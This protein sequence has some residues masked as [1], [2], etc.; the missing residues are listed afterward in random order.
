MRG[1]AYS[2]LWIFREF[3]ITPAYAGKSCKTWLRLAGCG[4]KIPRTRATRAVWGSPPHM[5]GKAE[6]TA[7]GALEGRITPAYA[8]KRL[9]QS[10]LR[11][12]RWDHPRI[13]GEKER[14][15]RRISNGM[16]SPPHMRGKVRRSLL[17]CPAHR[18]TPAYAGKSQEI[19]QPAEI[20]RD[21]PRICGEKQDVKLTM[22]AGQGSPPH[23]RGK[24]L[25]QRRLLRL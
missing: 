15:H 13:C 2:D 1:K 19:D 21:H 7:L 20:D 9:W 22:N 24:A 18:I 4:E 12:R 16:G 10:L 5:R 14:R 25:S 3:G 17:S 11:L 6:Q 23:M 8:G